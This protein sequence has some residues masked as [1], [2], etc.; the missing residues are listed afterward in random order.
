MESVDIRVERGVRKLDKVEPTWREHVDI[1][2]LDI[3]A[4]DC[5]VLGQVFGD[6]VSGLLTLGIEIGHGHIWGFDIENDYESAEG[7]AEIADLEDAWACEIG[8]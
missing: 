7:W 1:E 5:C 8:G 3:S 2:Y 4:G 6:Y